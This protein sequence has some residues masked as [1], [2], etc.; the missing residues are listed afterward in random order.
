MTLTGI[1]ETALP[2]IFEPFY[3]V[4]PSGSRSLVGSRLVLSIARIIARL[5]A[6]GRKPNRRRRSFHCKYI[7][8][9]EA[10]IRALLRRDITIREIELF[11]GPL[12]LHTAKK[13]VFWQEVRVELTKKEYIILEYLMTH[14]DKVISSE[15]LIEHVWDSEA[16]PF[17]NSF[18]FHI[19]S[20]R[21]KLTMV[22]GN[23]S[24]ITTVRGQ[25][26]CISKE[27]KTNE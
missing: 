4:D 15:E 8:E 20:L 6:G 12:R 27:E 11:H 21:K 24:L 7:A 17:S 23:D 16:E 3:C 26:Y 25:G 10:R 14:Q 19:S 1:P 9:L 18:R 5:D 2:Y 13:Q 22:S